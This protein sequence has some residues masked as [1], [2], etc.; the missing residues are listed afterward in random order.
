MNSESLSKI[1]ITSLFRT[2]NQK[3]PILKGQQKLR[4]RER[5]EKKHVEGRCKNQRPNSTYF[6]FENL[7]QFLE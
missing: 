6:S 1:N 2:K 5:G 4:E 3:T 7:H